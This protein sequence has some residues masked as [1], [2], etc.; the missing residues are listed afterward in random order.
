MKSAYFNSFRSACSAIQ[1]RAWFKAL[2][3][4]FLGF[5]PFLI[6]CLTMLLYGCTTQF[7]S[8]SYA[9]QHACSYYSCCCLKKPKLGIVST[10]RY[11]QVQASLYYFHLSNFHQAKAGFMLSK[12]VTK[13]SV[14]KLS[15]KS[16]LRPLLHVW[17]SFIF[18]CLKFLQN[19]IENIFWQDV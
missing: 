16:S 1:K 9:Q 3:R 11:T 7:L 8:S 18:A 14:E 12:L 6:L 5:S 13:S 17:V 4:T 19:T 15:R 2:V 10:S